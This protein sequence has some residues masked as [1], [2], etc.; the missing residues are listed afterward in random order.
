MKFNFRLI[1]KTNNLLHQFLKRIEPAANARRYYRVPITRI[2]TRRSARV[3]RTTAFSCSKCATTFARVDHRKRH[4]VSCKKVAASFDCKECLL[5]FPVIE[6]LRQHMESTHSNT[7]KR[8]SEDEPQNPSKSRKIIESWCCR[9]CKEDFDSRSALYRHQL[10]QHGGS[11]NLQPVPWGDNSAPWEDEDGNVIDEM[12]KEEYE[13][14]RSHI[15]Q[16]SS[17]G[18]IRSDYN[19]PTNDLQEGVDPL[20]EQVQSI[21]DMETQAFRLNLAFGLILHNFETGEYRYFIPYQNE[22]LFDH[23][24]TI[25]TQNDLSKLKLKL[26]SMDISAYARKQRPDTKWKPHLI[27]NVIFFIHKTSYPLGHG[28]LPDFIKNNRCIISLVTSPNNRQHLYKDH[29]CAFRCL[30]MFHQQANFEDAV[31]TYYQQWRKY[32]K[33][34]LPE[35]AKEFKG[36]DMNDVADFERCFGIRVTIMELQKDGNAIPRHHPTTTFKDHLFMN[37]FEKHLSYIKN[38]KGYAKKYQ[39]PACDRH[40][41]QCS[42]IKRHLKTC[43][44]LTKY[45]LPGGMFKEQRTLFDELEEF[46][47][48]VPQSEQIF[49]W[50]AVYDFESILQKIEERNSLKLQWDRKHQPISVSISSNVSKFTETVCF[51][52]SDLDIL[53]GKM[54]DHLMQISLKTQKKAEAKWSDALS[55]LKHMKEQWKSEDSDRELDRDSNSEDELDED[56]DNSEENQ[57]LDPKGLMYKQ[58]KRLHGKLLAYC[59]QLPV[60]GFNSARY[61]INL[62]ISKFPKHLNISNDEHSFVVKKSNSYLCISTEF[63]RF[64]DISQYLAPGCSYSKFLKAYQVDEQKS[65]FPYEWFDS[66]EKLNFP[67]LPEYN[68]FYSSLKGL[69]V[70][71]TDN[72]K[73]GIDQYNDLKQIWIDKGMKTFKDFLVYYN[74]LDVGPFVKAVERFQEFY[75][76]RNLDV[77]KIA[78]SVPGIARAMLFRTAKANDVHFPL[79]G[80]DDEDLYQIVKKNIVGGPSIIFTR[81][82]KVGESFIRGNVEKPCKKIVGY[83]ANALYLWAIGQNMPTQM[84]GIIKK[85][86]SKFKVDSDRQ[87]KYMSMYYWMDFMAQQQ[88][89]HILHKLNYGRE[90]RVGPYLVDGYSPSTNT[91]YEFNGCRFH[92][93]DPSKCSITAKINSKKWKSRQANLCKRT[94]ERAEFLRQKGFNVVAIWECDYRI[95]IE[96]QVKAST[97]QQKYLPPFCKQ[98]RSRHISMHDI[99]QAVRSKALFGMVECDIHVPNKL[100]PHFAEMSPL[101]C[102]TDVSFKDMSPHIQSHV[103]ERELSTKP[104]K[105]LVGGMKANRLLL[106]TPLLKW[107]LEHGL[108]VTN[109]HK[110][111]EYI[112]NACFKEFQHDVSNARRTGDQ[113]PSMSIIADTMKLIGN[114]AYGSLIMDKEKHQ[115]LNYIEGESK[116]K[117]KVN[118]PRFKM[119]HELDDDMYEIEH[120]KVKIKL[121][122]PISLG[123]FILQYAKLRMLEFY[124]DCLLTHVNKCDFEYIEMDT[125]SA[126]FAI[127]GNCL[128]DIVKPSMKSAF[129]T[130]ISS[131]CA[132]TDQIADTNIFFPRECCNTHIRF[133]KRTPG[134]FKLEASGDEMVALSSKTY[135]LRDGECYKM[136]CKGI[137]KTAVKEPMTTFKDALFNRKTISASNRGF[138][139]RKN[140]IYSY[141][142]ERSGFSYFYCKRKLLNDGIN[143]APLDLTLCPWPDYNTFCF[144]AWHPLGMFFSC[145]I[146][147]EEQCFSSA[148][149]LLVYKKA[150]FHEQQDIAK[151]VFSIPSALQV[152]KLGETI[153]ATSEWYDKRDEILLSILKLKTLHVLDTLRQSRG[154]YLVYTDAFD[155]YLGCGLRK[156]VAILTNPKQFSGK[157]KVGEL[158]QIISADL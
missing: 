146:M 3:Q 79:F 99:L 138:R 101:F 47:I 131:N 121:D 75:T 102:T 127:S 45:E 70:L 107:Y 39:C 119:L 145:K 46:G 10:N 137:N 96:S 57:N 11:N 98:H 12:L 54:M 136:S 60:L 7:R 69:N 38:F 22:Q 88:Q 6:Q 42:H 90:K 106:A 80:K 82:H 30:A 16:Q 147:C 140:T 21:F 23:N 110:V 31:I 129:Q 15:L 148:S 13:T 157:N 59:S 117:L 36:L 72:N 1:M 154:K 40:F 14:N 143:T 124:Y 108:E 93:H 118:D 152:N 139:A 133:D 115:S 62:I 149:H 43:S 122:L 91:I 27:T 67:S 155:R 25:S 100:Y 34:S 52:E 116:A 92:G 86:G 58:L 49:P 9:T 18:Q 104:R 77:F 128:S 126:Y 66:V 142:Q 74:N 103:Q 35:Q 132:N 125:D 68:A 78:I 81:H 112:P 41:K 51:V 113:N 87:H 37:V 105:L 158:W 63:F 44:N 33:C 156:P 111:I 85:Y 56:E 73:S 84:Y 32:V 2:V 83:D 150:I 153:E 20:M 17:I 114:S 94:K 29:L 5:S 144:D 135:L 76:K 151:A 53:L 71:E 134:L 55:K 50:F 61:D 130:R 141:Q 64:L 65:F 97:I 28:S 48:C 120:A 123:Y 24:I 19:L 4:E 89:T 95:R 26:E 8:K 109:I